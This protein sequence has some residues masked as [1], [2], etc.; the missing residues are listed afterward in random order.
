VFLAGWI[1]RHLAPDAVVACNDVGALRF[2]GK[3]RVLDLEGIVS[4]EG[5]RWSSAGEGS[6]FA[7]LAR[8]RPDYVAL[9]PGW[10]T[11]TFEAGAVHVAQ[12]GRIVVQTLSGGPYMVVGKL[13]ADVMA[14]GHAPP[15]SAA[16]A[17]I[18]D[19]LDVS[20]LDAEAA[21]AYAFDD[22]MPAAA[23]AN[24]VFSGTTDGGAKVV[25]NGR[26]HHAFERFRVARGAALIGRFGP[27]EAVARIGVLFDGKPAGELTLPIVAERRWHEARIPLPPGEG[28]VEVT[29]VA[30]DE[31]PGP[32]GGWV[33]AH[34]WA[35]GS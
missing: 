1:D 18:V 2:L 15:E 26:R 3:R 8:E 31:N 10:F 16:G 13:D 25:D 29:L 34:W 24:G 7:L 23:R 33:S 27:S 11:D 20:D 17:P 35:V 32:K 22:T 19:D 14:S 30:E 4:P 28:P 5:L 6:L 21:H 9:Y 12:V